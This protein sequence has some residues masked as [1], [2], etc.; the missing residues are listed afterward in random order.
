M[1]S[2]TTAAEHDHDGCQEWRSVSNLT[3]K[4]CFPVHS[5]Q[6][7][8]ADSICYISRFS[9]L[10]WTALLECESRVQLLH[11]CLN[12]GGDCSVIFPHCYTINRQLNG[13][14]EQWKD[15][16]NVHR[17][18]ISDPPGRFTSLLKMFYYLMFSFFLLTFN[19][20][21]TKFVFLWLLIHP[22]CS[23]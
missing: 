10:R 13:A 4:V 19:F 14:L 23:W 7:K 21:W 6:A 9:E 20:G 1:N 2:S 3:L 5:S 12:I 17:R 8:A 15:L 22:L 18:Y 11:V 16:S